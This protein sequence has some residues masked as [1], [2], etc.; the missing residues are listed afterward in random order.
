MSLVTG[1]ALS[2]ASTFGARTSASTAPGSVRSRAYTGP[3]GVSTLASCSTVAP[4]LRA[5]PA[6]ASAGAL[7]EGPSTRSRDALAAARKCDTATARR[8]G[9]AK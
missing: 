8:R 5:K 6:T 4:C 1:S 7:A 3:F 2:A 9:V